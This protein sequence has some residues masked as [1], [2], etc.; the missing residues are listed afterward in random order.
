MQYDGQ[1][2]VLT[3]FSG[4]VSKLCLHMTAASGK[5]DFSQRQLKH[6]SMQ[7][8]EFSA[9]VAAMQLTSQ[10]FTLYRWLQRGAGMA[11]S[12]WYMQIP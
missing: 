7:I 5:S 10:V 9:A 11:C 3:A 2:P 6:C 4:Q 1:V 8:L 12:N